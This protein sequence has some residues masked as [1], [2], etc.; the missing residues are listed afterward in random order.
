GEAEGASGLGAA[1][2]GTRTV[3]APAA[4]LG[5]WA[6]TRGSPR[7]YVPRGARERGEGP[8]SRRRSSRDPLPAGLA[9][10]AGHGRTGRDGQVTGKDKEGPEMKVRPSVKTICVNCKVI[11][12]EGVVRVICSNPKHKQRQG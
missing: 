1:G 4:D 5:R 7:R 2:C 6:G 3:R 12:R 10:R 8:R 11:R 9:G